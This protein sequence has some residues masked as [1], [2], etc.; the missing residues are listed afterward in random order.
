MLYGALFFLIVA[1]IAD[2]LGFAGVAFAA[3]GFAA[4]VFFLFLVVFV[5]ALVKHLAEERAGD[6]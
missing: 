5:V 1:L 3:A 6:A 4:I 2:L